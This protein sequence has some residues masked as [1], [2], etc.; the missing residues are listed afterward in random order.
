VTDF[1]REVERVAVTGSYKKKSKLMWVENFAVPVHQD[2]GNIGH[3]DWRTYHR[4]LLFAVIA[5]KKIRESNVPM[6]IVPAFQ[7]IL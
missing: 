4:L 5:Q 1:L 7:G 3:K 2:K 6:I